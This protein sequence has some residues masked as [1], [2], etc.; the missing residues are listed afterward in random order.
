MGI[1][2][3]S[4][5]KTSKIPS[6]KIEMDQYLFSSRKIDIM[7]FHKKNMAVTY[8]NY[9]RES[10]AIYYQ[11]RPLFFFLKRSCEEFGLHDPF[12]GGMKSYSI[13]LLINS[14][15]RSLELTNLGE[16]LLKISLYFGFYHTYDYEI[17]YHHEIKF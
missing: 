1:R 10:L 13:F 8:V 15:I 16:I 12:N 7:I 6:L 11:I 9:I 5:N 4:Y 17:E 2:Q 14:I 3:L